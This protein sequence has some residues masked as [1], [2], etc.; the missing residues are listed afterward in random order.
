M[1]GISFLQGCSSREATDAPVGEPIPMPSEVTQSRLHG[2]SEKH[3]KLERERGWENKGGILGE[4]MHGGFYQNT[5][6]VL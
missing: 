4:A 6:C 3:M 1:G 5:L 2:V